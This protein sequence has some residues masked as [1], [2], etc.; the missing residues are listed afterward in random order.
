[1]DIYNSCPLE[2][3]LNQKYFIVPLQFVYLAKQWFLEVL[4]GLCLTWKMPIRTFLIYIPFCNQQVMI[5]VW[6]SLFVFYVVCKLPKTVR[7]LYYY[8]L[9]TSS[10]FS[11]TTFRLAF[12]F[13]VQG[14]YWCLQGSLPGHLYGTVLLAAH[15]VENNGNVYNYVFEISSFI[16]RL[17]SKMHITWG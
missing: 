17:I 5:L 16:R 13:C 2:Y 3:L 1:M 11:V 6:C 12:L 14:A 15:T 9:L 7:S 8:E 10:L 4:P